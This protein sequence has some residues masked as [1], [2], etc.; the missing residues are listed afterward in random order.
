[1]TE[2]S[3]PFDATRRRVTMALV[4]API[5][6][7][8][9][10]T[11]AQT[12]VIQVWPGTGCE[13]CHKWIEHLRANE[14]EVTTHE[15]GNKDARLRLGMPDEYG[16]CHTAEVGGY[17]IE[18]HVPAREIHRLLE[19]GLGA[20]GLSVPAMPRGSPGMDGPASY[21]VRDPYDVLLVRRNGSAI[22]YQSYR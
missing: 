9:R 22:V 21:N 16:S 6:A 5:L 3:E 7:S 14:F 13:C 17:A 11:A 18:G 8:P 2:H 4:L 1:M 19:E 12:P 10:S 20:L 15:G